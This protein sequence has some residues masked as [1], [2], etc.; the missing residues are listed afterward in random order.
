MPCS[1]P[2]RQSADAKRSS[3]KRRTLASSAPARYA[4]LRSHGAAELS[5]CHRQPSRGAAHS[6]EG[7]VSFLDSRKSPAAWGIGKSLPR[8]EAA[9]LLSGRGRY[10]DDFSLPRQAYACFVR[11]P[12]AHAL[13]ES[14]D[15]TEANGVPRVLAVLTGTDAANDGLRPIPPTARPRGMQ[16]PERPPGR[17]AKERS[18]WR[19]PL[20]PPILAWGTLVPAAPYWA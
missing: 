16:F 13:I 3:G 17:F 11:S 2:M 10:A 20:R 1:P 7:L 19:R 4:A 14:I 12:H 15:V 9:R 6:R 8:R 18:P 5:I